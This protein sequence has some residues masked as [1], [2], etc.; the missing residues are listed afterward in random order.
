MS[1]PEL[2]IIEIIFYTIV[3]GS[4]VYSA[5]LACLEEGL[6]IF[7][8]LGDFPATVLTFAFC[9]VLDINLSAKCAIYLF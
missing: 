9:L 8:E 2:F 6:S 5:I 4:G 7:L 3:L 1:R